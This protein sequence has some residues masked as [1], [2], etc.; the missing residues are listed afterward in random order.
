MYYLF[1]FFY[2]LYE[3]FGMVD[4]YVRQNAM[5][6]IGNM[7]MA[8]KSIQHSS[9]FFFDDRYGREQLGRIEIPLQSNPW[10]GELPCHLRPDTPVDAQAM[11]AGSSHVIQGR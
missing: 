11:G 5:P 10:S 1:V 9:H 7:R 4:R 2:S 8:F 3:C 6:Q